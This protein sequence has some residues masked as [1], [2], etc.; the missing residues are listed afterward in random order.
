MISPMQAKRFY[1]AR[2]AWLGDGAIA[3]QSMAQRRADTCLACSKH[4][5]KPLQE[6]LTSA[7]ANMVH[8]QLELK[9]QL[10][11]RVEGEAKLHTCGMCECWMPLKVWLTLE[12]A[13]E[14]SPDWLHFP[15]N[16]WLKVGD[17]A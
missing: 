10:E 14:V 16:C 8:S 12:R 11:M 5:E 9:N 2:R 1:Q 4:V 7:V 13:R 6:L 17:K 15:D 3:S